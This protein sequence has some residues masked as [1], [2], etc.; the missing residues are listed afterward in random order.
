MANSS[1]KA[2]SLSTIEMEDIRERWG[3]GERWD[4]CRA[5]DI[6]YFELVKAL[7]KA[8][9]IPPVQ[10][11]PWVGPNDMDHAIAKLWNAGIIERKVIADRLNVHVSTVGTSLDRQ[12]LC[13]RRV[14]VRVV[15][16]NAW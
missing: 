4:I 3:H 12:G 6:S 16:E 5:Y 8:K 13:A 15:P 14:R 2:S 11:E 1:R 9:I 10:S 7:R